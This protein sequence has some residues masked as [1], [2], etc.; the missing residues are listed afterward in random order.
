MT[1]PI[2]DPLQRLAAHLSLA[3]PGGPN[4]PAAACAA[5]REAL[6]LAQALGDAQATAR[7]GA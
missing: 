2:D 7:A 5:A 1:G 6:A 4:L 3:D